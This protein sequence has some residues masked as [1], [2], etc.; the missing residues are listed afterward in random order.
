LAVGVEPIERWNPAFAFTHVLHYVVEQEQQFLTWQG[1]FGFIQADP[2][3][4]CML[5]TRSVHETAQ[6]LERYGNRWS[7]F[8][9]HSVIRWRVGNAYYSFLREVYVISHWRALVLDVRVQPLADALF[10][11]DGWYESAVLSLY[12]GN[13]RYRDRDTVGRRWPQRC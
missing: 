7:E 13:H 10:R 5:W 1:C 6:I 9:I 11:G 3:A 8:E 12:A 4:N 2:L